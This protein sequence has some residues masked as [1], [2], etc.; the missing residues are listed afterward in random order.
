MTALNSWIVRR[1]RPG[2][3]RG[4]VDDGSKFS[5]I[6]PGYP[7]RMSLWCNRRLTSLGTVKRSDGGLANLCPS[8][9]S[10][11]A[12]GFFDSRASGQGSIRLTPACTR[13]NE[14]HGQRMPRRNRHAAQ[15][16]D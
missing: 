3:L 15:E 2:Q 1:S 14:V 10:G 9:V 12:D 11:Y 8:K 4:P 6:L 5:C 7:Y 16:S 13:M